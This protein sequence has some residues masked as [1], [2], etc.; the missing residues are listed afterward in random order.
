M[1]IKDWDEENRPREKLL[2]RG[3]QALTDA[4]LLAIFLRTGVKGKSALDLAHDL[5]KEFG[6]LRSLLGAE[7]GRFCQANGLGTVKYIQLQA[8]LELSKRYLSQCLQRGD[9][10]SSPDVTR[11]YLLTALGGKPYEVFACLFLDNKNRV[12]K[13]EELFFGT[14]D[15]ASVYPREV[16]R[17]VLDHNAAAVI[18]AHNHP[19]GV[20]DPSHADITITQVLKDILDKIKVRVLD[21]IIVGD[22]YSISLAERG[23]M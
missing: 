11:N 17:K 21:H 16:M 3:A 5:L 4:E 6:D 10:M 22:G 8:C 12:I 18:F 20:A 23:L 7:I 1:S 15:G 9:V 2:Q 19:S 14:V 13:F